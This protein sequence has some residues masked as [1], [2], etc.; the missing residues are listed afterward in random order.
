[1]EVSTNFPIVVLSFLILV[2]KESTDPPDGRLVRVYPPEA[3]ED[4]TTVE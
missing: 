1:M 2:G 4:K 3:T